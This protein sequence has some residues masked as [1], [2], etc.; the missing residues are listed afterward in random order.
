MRRLIL[1]LCLI[2]LAC[3]A[4][5]GKGLALTE[6][7]GAKVKFDVYHRPL[8]EIPLPNDFAT[9]F[10]R[11]ARRRSCA[12]REPGRRRPSGR[13][14]AR[15]VIDQL[16]GWGTFAPIT[17]GFTEPLDV[18]NVIRRHQGDDY[19]FRATTRS[20]SSTSRPT[21]PTSASAVPLDMG[22]GNFPLVLETP[23][24][25]PT[26]TR[27]RSEQLVF[28][29]VDEDLEQ[30]GKLDPGEDT[31]MDGVLDHGNYARSR[32]TATST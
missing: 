6:G 31:D 8:P 30:N 10:D 16:D 7:D 22:E 13:A 29:E 12:Q 20:S 27:Y 28:D 15:E 5:E 4:P 24:L 32:P 19:D 21:R 25:S 9:R 26:D 18:M 2:P 17:V 3:T 11:R 1:S 14:D 23:R